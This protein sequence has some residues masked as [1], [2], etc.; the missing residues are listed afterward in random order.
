MHPSA[1]HD[2]TLVV[3][4]EQPIE[5]VAIRRFYRDNEGQRCTQF[6]GEVYITAGHESE[7][8][9]NARLISAAPELLEA[10]RAQHEAIDRLFAALIACDKDFLP[11][12]SGQ[13]WEA[14]KAGHAAIAAAEGK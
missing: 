10:C 4:L 8:D 2:G 12:R 7:T 11:S 13:P 1:I 3:H 9:A 5:R 14:L 6:V